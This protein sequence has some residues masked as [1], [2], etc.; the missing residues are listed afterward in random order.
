M[1]S[2]TQRSAMANPNF[3]ALHNNQVMTDEQ[4]ETLRRQ[5]CVYSTICSQLVEMHRAMS[6]Q[7][8]SSV[9]TLLMGQHMLYDL[10]QG[11][12]GFRASAR[13]RWTP[14]QT[15]LQILENLFEQG[16]ATPS[17][18][19]IKEITMELSQHGQISETNVYNWFQNRK[20]RAKRKQLP[21]Q[22]GGESENET[23][24]EYPGEKRFKPQ[25]DSNAQNPKSGHSEADPQ[26]PNKSDDVVQH[27]PCTTDQKQFGIQDNDTP[28]LLP[29]ED[30]MRPHAS[31]GSTMIGVSGSA[32]H[33]S[34]ECLPEVKPIYSSVEV[35]NRDHD[36]TQAYT[37]G[38]GTTTGQADGKPWQ[39]PNVVV[40][41]RRM[42]GENAVLVDSRG[43]MVPTNDMGVSFHPLHA[44]EGYAVL[45][46]YQCASGVPVHALRANTSDPYGGT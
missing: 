41:V 37:H 30:E 20:A 39:V 12:P 21:S 40:D 34:V 7:Q 35:G 14:S 2:V 28:S 9:P 29:R 44:S 18:Q 24:D 17:K 3:V 13:Q 10:A 45:S 23:D 8:P 6:Q 43:H 27:R 46:Q 15:Q 11:N 33:E 25:R 31:F 32:E 4:M 22:R 16:H 1:P 26:A 36:A 19:K 5:I 38:S 42:F